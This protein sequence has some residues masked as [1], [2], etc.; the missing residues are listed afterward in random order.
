MLSK[1]MGRLLTT[2]I[3]IVFIRTGY[4]TSPVVC[5]SNGSML[6][7]ISSCK[8]GKTWCVQYQ[9]NGIPSN[10]RLPIVSPR[11][12]VCGASK[13]TWSDMFIELTSSAMAIASG[14][15]LAQVIISLLLQRCSRMYGGK[16]S[17]YVYTSI[18]CTLLAM[19]VRDTECGGSGDCKIK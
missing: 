6:H 16:L 1:V 5:E 12:D 15:A 4:L 14:M 10:R 17:H 7:G 19:A 9:I 11:S 2:L 13:S 3:K 18:D 8:L